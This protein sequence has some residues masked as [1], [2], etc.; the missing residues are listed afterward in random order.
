MGWFFLPIFSKQRDFFNI[1]YTG[2]WIKYQCEHNK[3]TTDNKEPRIF[4]PLRIERG[5]TLSL[6]V[7]PVNL[8]MRSKH[9]IRSKHYQSHVST[10]YTCLFSACFIV[11]DA[12]KARP[13]CF[14]ADWIASLQNSYTEAWTPNMTPVRHR[15]FKE[16]IKVNWA[17]KDGALSYCSL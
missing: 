8:V 7:S 4:K 16:I 12:N 1:F 9:G 13:C 11:W 5:I 14:V 10:T 17:H 2:I 15:A 6:Q 3:I